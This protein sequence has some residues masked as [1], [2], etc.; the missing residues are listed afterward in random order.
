M[1]SI[2]S[3]QSLDAADRRRYR[4]VAPAVLAIALAF[5]CATAGSA[6]AQ[7]SQSVTYVYDAG[8]RLIAV[9]NGA[10]NAA[11]YFYDSAGNLTSIATYSAPTFVVFYDTPNNGPGGMSFT[12]YGDGFS[13]TPSQNTVKFNGSNGTPATITASTLTSLTVVVSSGLNNGSVPLYVSSPNGSS[14]GSI[15]FTL[16]TN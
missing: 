5:F 7:S 13:T 15:N 6:R 1:R 9:V 8:S 3:V 10:G 4:R 11:Q 14:S 2:S 16:T 12:I